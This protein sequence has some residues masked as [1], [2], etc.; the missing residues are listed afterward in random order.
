MN[1]FSL[2]RRFLLRTRAINPAL[3]LI[4]TFVLF[5]A[6]D[7]IAQYATARSDSKDIPRMD[8]RGTVINSATGE[9]VPRA[10]V[11]LGGPE[12]HSMLTDGE[13][14]FSFEKVPVEYL[15]LQARRPGFFERP[16]TLV[17]P[18][19]AKNLVVKLTPAGTISGQVLDQNG[20][21][22]ESAQVRLMQQ[23]IIF[24]RRKWVN[25]NG[26]QT[27][28]QGRYR[29]PNLRPGNYII[30]V[31]PVMDA[32]VEGGK[33]GY[34][35]LFYPKAPDPASATPIQISAGE[36]KEADFEL[37]RVPVF[38]V[39]G[40]VTGP[41]TQ[42]INVFLTNASG[43]QLGMFSRQDPATGE[44]EV[45]GVPRGTY[46]LRARASSEQ[47]EQE[48]TA[49]TTISVTND[50]SGVVL[51]L[52]PPIMIPVEVRSDVAQPTG[53][54][55]RNRPPS[56]DVQAVPLGDTAE[57]G[58]YTRFGGSPDNGRYSLYLPESGSYNVVVSSYGGGYVRSATSGNTDLLTDPLVVP[59]AGNVDPIEVVLASNGARVTG[60]VR[61]A[62][63]PALVVAVPDSEGCQ[64]TVSGYGPQ[65]QFSF[66]SLAPG[67]YSF[68]AIRPQDQMDYSDR[69]SFKPFRS[70][71][72]RVTLSP[73][74]SADITLDLIESDQ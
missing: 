50:L 73:N 9:P 7:S 45:R 27:N 63:G 3:Y 39:S 70:K 69:D 61:G 1:S 34:A 18:D 28:D 60:V 46:T 49:K 55:S 41:K 26:T 64:P 30:A 31:G 57:M 72:V 59:A 16:V 24:G 42:G 36:Q 8:I 32:F 6:A 74:Q 66:L 58:G 51:L 33:T 20:E 22:V 5:P 25:A 38:K 2:R 17:Q 48:F 10:L 53:S 35:P 40:L 23:R 37:S 4:L 71:A 29:L 13:G 12:F 62:S 65:G 47:G 54:N 19:K 14:G 43:N 44:F 67:D 56:I 52:H 21:P 15:Y 11:T 68:Y